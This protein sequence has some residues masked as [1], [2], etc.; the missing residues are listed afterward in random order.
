MMVL[1]AFLALLSLSAV[2]AMV[3]IE[4]R[5]AAPNGFISQGAAPASNSLTLRFALAPNNLAGLEAKLASISTPGSSEFRQWLSKDDVKAFV[6]P[7]A[8][9]VAAFN[10]FASAN[11]LK[12][13][14]ISPN[15]DWVSL[16]MPVS[17]ANKLFATN[18]QLFTHPAM[19]GTITRTLSVSL[20]TELVGVVDVV[21]PTTD[22][23]DPN[24]RLLPSTN[25]I[26][27]KR[28]TP[29]SCDSSN[30]SGTGTIT[31]SCL[32]DIYGIPTTPATQSSNT[33]LVTGYVEEWA[34][35]ADLK[36]FLTLL[37]PD[38]S[39]NTTFSLL[40]TD[41]G[42]NPQGAFD[43]GT[44]ANLDI[45]YTVGIATGVPTTFLS[46]G[47]DDT[48]DGFATSLL[49]T[50][51]FLD[52]V[53]NPPSVM[54]TSYGSTED[55]FGASMV[56]KICSGYMALGAR[57]ISVLTASGDG[58]VRGN[59]DDE[60][61]CDDNDFMPV[62]PATCPFVTAVGSTIGFAPEV[63]INF[64]GGGFSNL[65]ATPDYQTA[66]VASFLKTIPSDFAGTFNKT[67]RGYPDVAL[68]GWNFEIVVDDE[69]GLVGGTSA[70]SPTFAGMIA[71]INDQLVAAG[72]P[73]LGFLNPF[74]YSTGSTAFTD[75]TSGHNSGFVCPAS[76][77][78][79]DA[80]AGWD[81]L[82]G[83]GSPRFPDLLAAASA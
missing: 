33:L 12:P 80:A 42:T 10:S 7:S 74:I 63:A 11:G 56:S 21:H 60:S 4:S 57:G 53:E 49:D 6:E 30:P 68:Q 59:H 79:F 77:V 70:S 38:M 58:G 76:S 73:V 13:T 1:K 82:T 14:V 15:G 2:S 5:P 62:F 32:Q 48:I 41:G 18:F 50:T 47:G 83:N 44:E 22:F 75:I 3:V 24:P 25:F 36:T 54:T 23:T 81:P 9:T 69:A 37:R 8:D 71:L 39:P 46:V 27:N 55:S 51:T 67:G 61:V 78:A 65:F 40:T 43:A 17:Q 72:K 19:D 29:A 34:Q 45:Q 64:T 35:A 52:G 26:R 31:P 66:A 28:D 16:T 20:P